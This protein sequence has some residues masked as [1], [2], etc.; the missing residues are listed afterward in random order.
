MRSIGRRE[1]VFIVL[2]SGLLFGTTG[3]MRVLSDV[4]ASATS[5]G[6]ARLAVGSLGLVL[7]TISQR[8]FGELVALWKR[9]RVW[10]MGFS[11][12]SYMLSFFT[13]VQ[14]AGAAVAALVSIAL[15]PM[16]AGGIARL[17]GKPWPGKVWLLSTVLAVIGVTLLSAPTGSQVGDHRVAGAL[18]GVIASASYAFFTVVGADLVAE[19]HH[20]TDSL[21]ASFSIGALMISPFL[22]MDLD[23][24]FT[25]RGIM[26]AL[27]LGLAST[28][29]S[30]VLFGVGITYLAPGVVATLLLSEPFLATLF[31][32]FLLGEPMV[33]RGWIGC[34]LIVIGL[35]IVSR[36]ESRTQVSAEAIG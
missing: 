26:L 7:V 9:P 1:A 4:E 34:A 35:V 13:A 21:S 12:G 31:G 5:I 15:S 6:A 32:V 29:L 8:G 10:I 18:F 3:T 30:Y 36:H 27:W 23:W 16:L 14:L 20:G 28:T 2:L 11:V 25:S 24:L 17:F 22:F 33:L 19:G